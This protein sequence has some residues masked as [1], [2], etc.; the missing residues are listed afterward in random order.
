MRTII[1][2]AA[3]AETI[4]WVAQALPSR[5]QIPVMA[6]IRLALDEDGLTLQAFDFETSHAA[7]LHEA[8]PEGDGR[9]GAI[10]S[11]WLLRALVAAL[12]SGQVTLDLGE[13]MVSVAAGRARYRIGLM[14]ADDAPALPIL[15]PMIGHIDGAE[16]AAMISSAAHPV[17]DSENG[18]PDLRGVRLDVSDGALTVIGA[19]RQVMAVRSADWSGDPL[20]VQVPHGVL[21][22]AVRGLESSDLAIGHQH[23]LLGLR[24]HVVSGERMVTTRTY[25]GKPM[26]WRRRLR[27]SDAD[28][29]VAM[30]ETSALVGALRRVALL[31]GEEETATLHVKETG[32]AL[33][34]VGHGNYGQGDEFVAATVLGLAPMSLGINPGWLAEAAQAMG[35]SRV[36]LGFGTTSRDAV[37]V[38]PLVED[39][40][41][42]PRAVTVL[43][44]RAERAAQGVAA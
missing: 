35:T 43:M 9:A 32:L 6:G 26:P 4:G 38:R 10:V 1:D 23:G 40:R 18:H 3:L 2:Q 7:I 33:D 13:D 42:D 12:P 25:A 19:S 24:G 28:V 39:D 36:W 21:Q 14:S 11:G 22:G 16:F 34:V 44:P 30:V 8:H 27:D 41:S 31:S 20:S 29:I 37:T 15:P 17:D 5:P